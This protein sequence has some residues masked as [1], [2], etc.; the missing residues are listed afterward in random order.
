LRDCTD[1]AVLR[2]FLLAELERR[3]RALYGQ[4]H[5]LPLI[6]QLESARQRLARVAEV[7]ANER[8][9]GWVIAEV[10]KK[11]S[12]EIGGLLVKGKI[13]RIDRHEKTGAVRVLDY[14]T[15]D[16]PASPRD[17]HFRAP[18]EEVALPKWA[19]LDLDGRPRVWA[20]LQLPLYLQALAAEFPGSVA[21][22]YFNLPKAAGGTDLALWGDYTPELHA[23]ALRC[24]EGACAAIRA[25]EFWPPNEQVRADH[26]E[27]ATL[28]QHGAAASVA[29]TEAKP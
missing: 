19:A 10:E 24:A 7:Q 22:G 5:S 23:A 3:A 12:I 8:A 6:I 14:K 1:A 20:D 21:C 27:F 18:R 11:F 4:A 29:W 9:A 13:D 25:G 28:F 17:T 2:Q 16:A 26:D 15:S